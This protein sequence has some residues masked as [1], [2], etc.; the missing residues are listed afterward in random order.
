MQGLDSEK[1]EITEVGEGEY[2]VLAAFPKE[3]EDATTLDEEVQRLLHIVSKGKGDTEMVGGRREVGD[4][5]EETGAIQTG[6]DE[7][8]EDVQVAVDGELGG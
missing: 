3:E 4:G 1:D 2:V 7:A 6:L 5:V 8:L